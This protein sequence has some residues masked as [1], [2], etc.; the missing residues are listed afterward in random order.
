MR[1]HP[2]GAGS[3]DAPQTPARPAGPSLSRRGLLLLGGAGLASPLLAGLTSSGPLPARTTPLVPRGDDD[4][5]LD[6]R[7]YGAEGDGR[8]DDTRAL[9]RLLDASARRGRVAYVPAGTYR[10]T[11]GLLLRS[12][13][14]LHLARRARL[15][16]DW[17]APPG[18]TDAFLRNADFAVKSDR[19]RITGSGTIGARDHGM[20]GVVLALYGDDVTIS[21]ITIDTYA[22]G[23]AVMFAGDRG[24]IDGITVRGSAPVFGTGGIRVIGGADFLGTGCHVE[25]GDDC[26]QFVPIGNPAAE[27]T[28]Y[29]QSIT[30]GRFVG[31]TGTSTASR[32]L[33]AVL[34]WTGGETGMTGAIR[35]CS[36][37]DCHGAG[38]GRGIGIKNTHSSGG[39]ERL[40][41]TDCSVEVSNAADEQSQGIRV[42]TGEGV[43]AAIRD[44]T[45]TR[46][47]V[48]R[49]ANTAMRVGGP[50]ISGLTFDSC[51]FEAPSG[52]A[53]TVVVVDGTERP[54]FRGCTFTGG[55]GK[56]LLVAGPVNPVTALSVEDCRFTGIDGAWAVD[57]VRADGARIAGSTF[58]E[59]P[60]ATTA[61]A[62]RLAPGAVGAVVEDNDS[63]GISHPEPVTD[64][65]TGTVVRGNTG[66]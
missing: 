9:Q 3:P 8:A 25:S 53:P 66:A 33:V 51:T 10:C 7:D 64:R 14:Q 5:V 35:D 28:L 63:T 12:D 11:A 38:A 23:Q 21:D 65:G 32:F 46:T 6:A 17:A 45:F 58:Q 57:V 50:G 24:R 19:V 15:V 56:R 44:V 54:L 39:I 55:P 40:R 52:A 42:Q 20:T 2:S 59:A 31:C 1:D 48:L 36:F 26:F 4:D 43:G 27:P 30:G 62:V 18:M 29:D 61:R 60:G 13:V 37:T 34:E 47:Q 49:P 16:K 22:G 41:F